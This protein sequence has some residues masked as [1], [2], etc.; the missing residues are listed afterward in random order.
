VDVLHDTFYL[1]YHSNHDFTLITKLLWIFSQSGFY[2]LLKEIDFQ[3]K[4]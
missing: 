2:K 3:P 1:L 4:F